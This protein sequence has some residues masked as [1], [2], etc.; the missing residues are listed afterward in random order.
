MFTILMLQCVHVRLVFRPIGFI[1]AEN[2]SA[3]CEISIT[4]KGLL[5]REPIQ[6]K[7]YSTVWFYDTGI[8]FLDG[9]T[10]DDEYI[11][12]IQPLFSV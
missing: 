1:I 3:L 10:Q 11:L 6:A 9:N 7:T 5:S 8:E 2:Q 12:T 4:A